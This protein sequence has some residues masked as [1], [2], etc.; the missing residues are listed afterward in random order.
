MLLLAVSTSTPMASVAFGLDGEELARASLSRPH[1][2]DEFLAPAIEFCSRHAGVSVESL[3]GV[4]IDNG[5]GLFTGLRVGI[6][7]ARAIAT[8][9]SI[10]MFAIS[11]LDLLALAARHSNREIVAVLDAR[12]G[13]VYSAFYRPAPGGVQR[14][15]DYTVQS[16]DALVDDL[17][18]RSEDV[19]A[20]GDG[21]RTYADSIGRVGGVTLADPSLAHPWAETALAIGAEH[22]EREEFVPPAQIEP[23][24]LRKSDAEINWARR[25]ERG[26]KTAGGD[27]EVG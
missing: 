8:T 10:P 1:A 12:R 9:L 2:H 23:L 15:S 4:I 24:Y 19:L 6:A 13:E 21:A 16:P 20:V 22:F 17:I 7:T 3:A 5:P 11:S 27:V 25:R 18:A 14:V 26:G